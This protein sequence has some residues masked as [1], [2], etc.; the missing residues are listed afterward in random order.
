MPRKPTEYSLQDLASSSLD[1][2]VV[3]S[4]ELKNMPKISARQF[5]AL[6]GVS[7]FT[8]GDIYQKYLLATHFQHPRYL[9]WTLFFCWTYPTA[10]LSYLPFW[11]CNSR[12]FSEAVWEVL[13]YLS[14]NFQ[15][16]RFLF[17]YS[18]F[19]IFFRLKLRIE[20]AQY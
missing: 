7:H 6:F 18:S 1:W 3:A 13:L 12:T 5:R 10:S 17:I 16:V 4:L 19:H 15:E 8:A 2:L 20:E 14:E 9:L 11:C